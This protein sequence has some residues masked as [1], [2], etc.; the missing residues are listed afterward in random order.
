MR[1]PPVKAIIAFESVARTGSVNRASEELGL[2]ASA[3]S[4]QISNLESIIGQTL[5]YRS[6]RGLVLTPTGE[7]PNVRRAAPRSTFCA[8]IR[9]PASG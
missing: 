9:A 3:V 7:R 5:F 8:C 4:H 6:G 2:T 1:I